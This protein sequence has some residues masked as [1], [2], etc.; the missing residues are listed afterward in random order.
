MNPLLGTRVIDKSKVDQ[1]TTD[2]ES[3]LLQGLAARGRL[4]LLVRIGRV[5]ARIAAQH[6]DPGRQ[7]E[8]RRLLPCPHALEHGHQRPQ[9]GHQHEGPQD[10]VP[11]AAAPPRLRAR[12]LVD[13]HGWERMGRPLARLQASADE[14]LRVVKGRRVRQQHWTRKRPTA[15][16][17]SERC[18]GVLPKCDQRLRNY[19][20]SRPAGEGEMARIARLRSLPMRSNAIPYER[21]K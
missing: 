2:I 6:H 21:R 12:Y 3:G 5:Q 7:R 18:F 11:P 16:V 14:A 17:R 9:Q 15:I 4:E 1:G 19:A 20:L 13:G 10:I 8:G